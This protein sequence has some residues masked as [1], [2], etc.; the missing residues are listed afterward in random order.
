MMHTPDSI[1]AIRTDL[2]R[3]SCNDSSHP[4]GPL[5]AT[6]PRPATN[7]Y[8][9]WAGLGP[10]IP[11]WLL[12]HHAH[13]LSQNHHVHSQQASSTP[14]PRSALC[15]PRRMG[16]SPPYTPTLTT[17]QGTPGSHA[18]CRVSLLSLTAPT[19][20]VAAGCTHRHAAAPAPPC[21]HH[22]PYPRHSHHTR[23]PAAPRRRHHSCCHCGRRSCCSPRRRLCERTRPHHSRRRPA[24]CCC[25]RRRRC[26]RCHTCRAGPTVGWSAQVVVDMVATIQHI[27][28][29]FSM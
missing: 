23:H 14:R 8:T 16:G 2:Q 29:R 7:I 26:G 3:C 17:H 20:R 13:C 1:P 11:R 15:P 4:R 10:F 9:G 12:H 21:H 6:S 22:R 25:S 19:G 18:P 28:Q 27:H 24:R 5:P